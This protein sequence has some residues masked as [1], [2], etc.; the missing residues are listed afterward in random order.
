MSDQEHPARVNRAAIVAEI[1]TRT[2]ID[3]AMIEHLVHE[4]YARARRDPLIG[5]VFDSRV[6]DWPAHLAQM[7][8]FW[9]S[10]TLMT[11]RYHG[12][13]MAKHWPLP[14]ERRHFD[15]WLALFAQTAQELCPQPARDFLVDRAHR[16]AD[17]LELGIAVQQ[18]HV[19]RRA[20]GIQR[21]Q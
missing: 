15:R 17:S 18:G 14:I 9:S 4:F 2:G 21:P 20:D 13:P 3:E 6:A 7:C 5:P 11:G 19:P 12:A 8:A 16:I 1:V 10:V